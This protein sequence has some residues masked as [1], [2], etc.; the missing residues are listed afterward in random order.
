[1]T[2]HCCDRS[3]PSVSYRGLQKVDSQDAALI[4]SDFG[5]YLRGLGYSPY[6]VAFYQRR[7][8][9]LAN[10]LGEHCHRPRMT[11]LTREEAPHLLKRFLPGKRPNTLVCFRKPLFQ[12]LRFQGRFTPSIPPVGWQEWLDDY[13]D[14]LRIHRGVAYTTIQRA[15]ANVSALLNALFGNGKANWARVQPADLWRFALRH[16]RG[17]SA[18]YAEDRL[19]QVRRFLQFVVMQGACSQRLLMAFPKVANYGS[20]TRPSILS[21]EQEPELLAC[22]DRRSSEGN[23]DY[24]MSLCMLHLGL[25]AGEVVRLQLGGVDCKNRRS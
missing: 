1:M 4:R 6:T 8:L 17:V 25:R 9:R 2:K 13:L 20:C 12:W 7:L 5:E 23:R 24:A 18:S 11:E 14:F 15:Q 22:F 19:G 16:T 3:P 10:W 21:K